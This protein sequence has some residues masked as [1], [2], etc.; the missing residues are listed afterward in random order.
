M[1][2]AQSQVHR[3]DKAGALSLASAESREKVIDREIDR[4][5][6]APVKQEFPYAI[7]NVQWSQITG[8]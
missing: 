6:S 2:E 1:S 5:L 3:K 4:N 8:L 7:Q